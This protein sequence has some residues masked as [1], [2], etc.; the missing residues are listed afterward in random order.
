MSQRAVTY[1]YI[2]VEKLIKNN[3]DCETSR[4]R[5]RGL[6]IIARVKAVLG[7]SDAPATILSISYETTA[8]N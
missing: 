8:T 6:A 1:M 2:V 4:G 5:E 3:K 7:Q